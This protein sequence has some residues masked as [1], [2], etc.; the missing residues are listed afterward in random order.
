MN[1]NSQGG[2]RRFRPRCSC[3]CD[4]GGVLPPQALPQLLQRGAQG[5][6]LEHE[7]LQ[8]GKPG[9]VGPKNRRLTHTNSKVAKS[10]DVRKMTAKSQA[11]NEP[12]KKSSADRDSFFFAPELFC[13][14]EGKQ[15]V[16]AIYVQS[17]PSSIAGPP[18]TDGQVSKEID[19]AGSDPPKTQPPAARKN[20]RLFKSCC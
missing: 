20:E 7:G 17:L 13:A 8:E 6:D 14:Q 16:F 9:Q 2:R 12:R 18:S 4:P 10:P 3:S 15:S 11:N 1:L 19:R 5:R